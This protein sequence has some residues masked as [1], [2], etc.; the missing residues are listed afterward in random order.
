MNVGVLRVLQAF[1]A[2]AAAVILFITSL[3]LFRNTGLPADPRSMAT[4][5]SLMRHPTLIE[6][7]NHV[8][9]NASSQDMQRVLQ[10]K[11]Y[12][13]GSFRCANGENAYGIR[14]ADGSVD[15]NHA[16][17]STTDA[18]K[19]TPVE[20]FSPFSDRG[21]LALRGRFRIQDLVLALVV[22]GSFGVVLAYYLDGNNDGFN[23]FFESNTFG[24][25][26]ILTLAG[27]LT[28]TLWKSVEQCKCLSLC[29]SLRPR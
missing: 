26:F 18:H 2:I 27:T 14:P 3:I 8:P 24:P 9:V 11:M 23:R 10:G 4:I 20:G 22:L 7:L 5:A 21:S 6:D 28:A 13:L 15:V 19:Y 25:R 1:L 29:T 12:R 17:L 16:I